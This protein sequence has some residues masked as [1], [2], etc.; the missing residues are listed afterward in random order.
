[1]KPRSAK[2][3]GR[4]F[5]NIVAESILEKFPELKPDDCRT[6]VMGESGEDLKFSPAAR[7]LLSISVECKNVEKLNV[8][9]SW[10]QAA[11][12]TPDGARSVLAITRNRSPNL[13]VVELNFLLQLM[14]EVNGVTP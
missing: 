10:E 3:K 6:A 2:A 14:R 9:K 4:R 5:Q 12:N 8:W 1:M 11:T 7:K 13:A